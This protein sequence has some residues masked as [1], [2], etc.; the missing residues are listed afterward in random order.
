MIEQIAFNAGG[1]S[2]ATCN[3]LNPDHDVPYMPTL[4]FD[5][6]CDASQPIVSAMSASSRAVYSPAGSPSDEPVPLTSSRHTMYPNSSANRWYSSPYDA[7]RSS[8][9]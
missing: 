3:E 4:P 6:A 5:H 1:R 9:R 7:V 2:I 8:L